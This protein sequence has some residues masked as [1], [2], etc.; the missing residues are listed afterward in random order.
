[1][2]TDDTR[3][4]H[5]AAASSNN[6]AE[7]ERALRESEERFRELTDLLPEGVFESDAQGLITYTN[8][9][10]LELTGYSAEDL[11]R[12]VNVLDVFTTGDRKRGAEHFSALLRGETPGPKEY[13]IR[14]KDGSTKQVAMHSASIRRGDQI[15]GI[16]GVISD[17]ASLKAVEEALRTSEL[18]YRRVWE[19]A[20]LAFVVS[21]RDC[22]VTDWNPC[23]AALF[24]WTRE[25]VLGRSFFDFLIPEVVRP[26]VEV[27]VQRLLADEL[28]SH[29]VN[30]NLTKNGELITCEW[31]N[32][33]LLDP[34]GEVVG[35]L[36]LALDISERRRAEEA[37]KASEDK[38][39]LITERA[40]MGIVVTDEQS[41]IIEVNT[42]LCRILEQSREALLGGSWSTLLCGQE[43]ERAEQV[44]RRLRTRGQLEGEE[45]TLG[46]KTLGITSSV[47]TQ[48][49]WRVISLVQDI[50][51]TKRLEEQLRQAQKMDALGNLAGG[52]AHDL[53]NM[54]S[55]IMSL[56]LVLKDDM[57]AEHDANRDLDGI[58]AACRRGQGLTRNLLGFARQSPS[59]REPL[60]INRLVHEA[61]DLLERTISKKIVIELQLDDELA[62]VEGD[63]SHLNQLMINLGLNAADAMRKG[64]TLTYSTT[65]VRLDQGEAEL[66]ELRSGRYVHVQVHDT[67]TGMPPTALE[68]AFE[69]FFTTK[70]EGAG[71]GLGL[72]L[73]YGTAKKHGGVARIES[74][75]G[76]GTT[77]NVYLPATS[78]LARELV[79][80]AE[81]SVGFLPASGTILLVDDEELIRSSGRRLLQKLGFTVLLAEN[82]QAALEVYKEH[83]L[84]IDLV[85]L[86]LIMP[87]MDGA[88]AYS[89]LREF[90]P[91]VRIVPSSGYTSE[92]VAD[93]LQELGA[94]EFVHKPYNLKQLS[95]ALARALE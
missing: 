17:I 35:V 14:R 44:R 89:R 2:P 32:V 52:V 90:D 27:V 56:T 83:A 18:R 58:V 62:V 38:Y 40:P 60:S 43:L 75:E 92:E 81:S 3:P 28:P 55:A 68:R 19:S 42:T 88:E 50:S 51:Q 85:I 53:N 95:A 31:S 47:L 5:D 23:A 72:S 94:G 61:S 79:D 21:D 78:G 13:K 37:L 77:A 71:T 24:G 16:R 49:P 73:V 64:G 45:L 22:I 67:G 11:E 8:A 1:M 76:S 69:P 12:G 39:R 9:R 54:L 57:G 29:G 48:L 66:L 36:S 7:T 93:K 10:G 26:P 41:V 87:V 63:P 91:D 15:V 25:E 70:P 86:D 33:R 20:P 82:G 59:L 65:N 6:R 84:E 30:E 4:H 34:D 80:T 46:D 74:Q